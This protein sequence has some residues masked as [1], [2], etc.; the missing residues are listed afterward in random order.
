[1]SKKLLV[2]LF[3][4]SLLFACNTKKNENPEE[5]VKWPDVKPP[6]A[7]TKVHWRTIHGDSVLDNYYWMYDYFGKGPDSS[8]VVDYLKAENAYLDTMMSGTKKLQADLF[9]EMKS[10]IKEKDENVPVFKNGYYYYYRTEEGKQY[11][12]YCRKKG[13]LDAAEEVLLDVDKMAEGHAYFSAGGFDVSE[14]NKLLAYGVD[15]VSRRQ[16]TIYIKNLET[17]QILPDVV[18]G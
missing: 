15:D 1:M 4:A 14:D 5:M 7:E 13:S 17:G 2:A 9:T 12:K 3:A 10:R 11:F 6:V 16:Y 18:K 8:S